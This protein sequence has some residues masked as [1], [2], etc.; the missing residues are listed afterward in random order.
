MKG[1]YVKSLASLTVTGLIG[2]LF[3]CQQMLKSFNIYINIVWYLFMTIEFGGGVI[4]YYIVKNKRLNER[5]YQLDIQNKM[6]EKNYVQISE[7]YRS[8]AKLYH[9]MRHHLNVV[10]Y[11][12]EKGE[13]GQ[14]KQYVESLKNAGGFLTVKKRTG[15]DVVDVVLS[16]LERQAAG[17][18]VSVFIKS[19]ILAQDINIEQRDLCVLLAN[20]MDNAVEAAQEEIKVAIKRIQDMLIICVQN[21]CHMLPLRKNGKFQTTKKDRINHGW[22]IQ[23][24]EDIVQKYQGSIEY[25]TQDDKFFVDIMINV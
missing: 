6:L 8:N 3:I 13:T 11:I 2:F 21:D 16:E 18:A 4:V 23:N 5:L 12:L 9:D 1:V 24:I 10:C 25:R 14:A 22:G 15:L 7:F 20:L 19:Q 17:K